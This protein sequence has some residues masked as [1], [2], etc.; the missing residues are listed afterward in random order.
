VVVIAGR[1]FRPCFNR[2]QSPDKSVIGMWILGLGG[3]IPT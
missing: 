3:Q 1:C 2:K